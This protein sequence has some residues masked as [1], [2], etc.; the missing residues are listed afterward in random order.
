MIKL[1]YNAYK[2]LS[3]R[4]YGLFFEDI[5]FSIDGGMNNNQISNRTHEMTYI[6]YK[7]D[8]AYY[9]FRVFHARRKYMTKCERPVP[10]RFWTSEGEGKLDYAENNPINATNTH[11]AAITVAGCFKVGNLGYNGGDSPDTKGR[12]LRRNVDKAAIGVKEGEE[13]DIAV[14]LKNDDFKGDITFYVETPE[15]KLTD[16]ATVNITDKWTKVT[17]KVRGVRTGIG[18]F[19]AECNGKGRFFADEWY[20]GA[21]DYWGKDNPKWTGG[22]LRKEL[23]EL[24]ADLKPRFIRFPGGCLVEGYNLANSYDWKRSVG[25]VEER[26]SMFNLWGESQKELSYEQSFEM[27]FYEYFLLCEELNAMALPILNAGLACQGRSSEVAVPGDAEYDRIKNNILDLIDY[28]NGDPKTNKWAK[29][30]ADSGHPE[31]FGLKMLGIGNENFGERYQ[32]NFDSLR[33]AVKEKAPEMEVIW[34]AGWDCYKTDHYEERRKGFDGKHDDCISDDHFYREPK[35]CI[36]WTNHYDTYDRS[37]ARIFLGEYAANSPWDST[38]LP[39]N[40]Y[41]ALA[42][43]AYLTGLE[44]NGDIVIMSSYAPLFSRVG[45]EQW[46]HNMINYNSLYS[47]KTTNYFVQK[48]FSANFGT[49]Y[50]NHE[51][52]DKEVF[53]SVTADDKYLYIKLVNVAK[54]E[55][56]VEYAFENMTLSD[57]EWTEM[58]C[59]D[60]YAR[61]E[62]TWDGK[63]VYNIQPTTTAIQVT[64]TLSVTLKARSINLI[65]LQLN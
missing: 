44:R 61:N 17:A 4:F 9:Y 63:P 8:F 32:A 47:L 56:T 10:L 25:K 27:G 19:V 39:N 57:G 60:N 49:R 64:D 31:P 65:K 7:H 3:D 6:D 62:L 46:K 22:R 11:Y 37:R 50:I 29:L 35:W 41:S 28:A 12:Y 5:N 16:T 34:C 14:F 53:S 21:A 42:E 54:T 58:S 1:D 40:Y 26:R 55:K 15:G 38:A 48:L 51:A 24:L 20:F 30:R 52:A 43:A 36:E 18:K 45:G 2:T 13:Y 23:V 59:T 33:A